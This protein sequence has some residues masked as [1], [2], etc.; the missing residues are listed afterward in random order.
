MSDKRLKATV[1]DR[2]GGGIDGNAGG[3]GKLVHKDAED[4]GGTSILSFSS[5]DI[6]DLRFLILAGAS[7][8]Y[9]VGVDRLTGERRA[10][11]V[12]PLPLEA[13]VEAVEASGAGSLRITQLVNHPVLGADSVA[14]EAADV[15]KGDQGKL[16]E[17]S[18]VLVQVAL[19]EQQVVAKEVRRFY[20]MKESEKMPEH[21]KRQQAVAKRS[22]R[23]AIGPARAVRHTVT[24]THA[25]THTHTHTRT[26]AH[27][28][29]HTG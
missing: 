23:L 16:V 20:K 13:V 1:T 8:E 26:H 12:A 24:H 4:G 19:A 25:R 27:T 6:I 5:A 17:G 21:M 3:G 7:V 15:V 9:S 2:P 18:D 10:R 29:T 11:N 22:E 28:H 14:F